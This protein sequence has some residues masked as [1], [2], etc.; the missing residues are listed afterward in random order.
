MKTNVIQE[1]PDPALDRITAEP[2]R[3]TAAQRPRP[4]GAGR[5]LITVFGGIGLLLAVAFLVSGAAALFALGGRDADGYFMSGAHRI[6]TPSNAL[7]SER[8]DVDADA[9]SWIF[10]E[11]FATS[12][13]EASSSQP[14]F[15]GI[16]PSADVERYLDRVRHA[17]ITDVDTDPFRVTS[18]L[19]PGGAQPAAPATE[20]FWRVESSGTG[21]RTVTWPL[22]RGQWSVVM[23]N[24][25]G[26][27]GVDV[28]A[29]LGARV[30]SLRWV[31]IGLLATGAV[32]LL[33]GGVLLRL[34]TA[35]RRPARR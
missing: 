10:G 27:P 21:A 26:S 6:A 25:D 13:I 30:P 17:E 23:M 34:G 4:A 5:V 28:Q 1:E 22:E 2:R 15:V 7:A 8:L 35:G 31:G 32:A 18:H 20:R 29:K 24:A 3:A 16:G 12:R 11:G 33:I 14:V 19:V 9:P